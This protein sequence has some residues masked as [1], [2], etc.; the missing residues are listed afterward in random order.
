MPIFVKTACQPQELEQ[1]FAIRRKVFIEEQQVPEEL[2]LDE[3]DGQS[4][5]FLALEQNTPVG[6]CR[7]R[8]LDARTAKAERVAVLRTKRNTGAGKKLMEA[9]EAHAGKKGALSIVLNAQ[10]QVVPFYEKLGYQA[11]GTPFFEA[12]IK[13]IPMKKELA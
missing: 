7:L 8:W 10:I 1:A 2:E 6:T 9:L 13:H 3:W 11:A 5:H 4:T 12:G